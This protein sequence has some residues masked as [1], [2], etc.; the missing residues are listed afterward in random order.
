MADIL[1][2]KHDLLEFVNGLK[3]KYELSKTVGEDYYEPGMMEN[4]EQYRGEYVEQVNMIFLR[5]ESKGLR[6]DNQTQNLERVS[7]GDEVR[8]VRDND[9]PF[10][11]NNFAIKSN[12]NE[13]LGNLPAEL[14]NALAPLYDA[15]YATILTATVSYI[16]RLK[17]RSRYAKQGVMFV[18]LNIKMRGI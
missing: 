13:A 18:E 3:Y 5:V 2:A 8:I 12:K 16:E 4:L 1:Q 7:V 10:N 17:D 11:S 9:N 6:Y 14:C 15:G